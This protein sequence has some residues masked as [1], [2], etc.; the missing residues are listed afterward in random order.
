MIRISASAFD[1]LWTD[2]GHDRPPE[3]L[4]VRSVG[5]TDAERAEVR[6]AVY[7]N[8]AE[9]GLY[10]G[11]RLEPALASRLNLLADAD[12]FVACEALADMTA[13][14]PFRAVTA[15]R[16]RRGVLA[17][18]PE[19]T[20]GLDSIRDGELGTAIVDVLPELSAGPGYGISLPASTL[21][22]AAD[23]G[24]GSASAQLEEVRAIQARPVYAAGQFSVSRRSGSGRPARVGGLTWFD[25]DVGAYC[26]TKT[27]GRGGQEW[28]TVSPVDSTRLAARVTALLT[29][30]D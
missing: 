16:G 7:D 5:G 13:A 25:T 11:S 1:I 26:A 4:S 30:E 2:L 19:Q 21:S 8:L 28:V 9:R 3:P 27:S 20:I 10:D 23:A 29:P 22:G 14:T 17:T 12:V 15:A 24:S 18:Q 6:K